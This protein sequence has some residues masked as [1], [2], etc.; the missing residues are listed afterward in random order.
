ALNLKSVFLCA[1]AEF[2]SMV[3]NGKGSIINTASISGVIVNRGTNHA[4]Y[5]TAKAGVWMFTRCLAMEVWRYG[6]DVNELVPGPVLTDL[7]KDI[8]QLDQAPPIAES[9]RVKTPDE[10]VPLTIYLA[11]HPPGGPTGQSFSLARRPI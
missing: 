5:N 8:F 7:T 9:E 2:K 1:Q 11:T 6:I 10:C 3:T 4:A